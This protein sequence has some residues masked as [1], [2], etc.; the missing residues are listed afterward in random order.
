MAAGMPSPDVVQL[1]EVLIRTQAGPPAT[2]SFKTTVL[3]AGRA[4]GVIYSPLSL[5]NLSDGSARVR[6]P[7]KDRAFSRLRRDPRVRRGSPRARRAKGIRRAPRA[8]SPPPWPAR[9]A[10]RDD[11]EAVRRT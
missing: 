4:T 9:P 10:N 5:P 11:A 8:A 6:R 3:T 7:H 2:G 1:Q